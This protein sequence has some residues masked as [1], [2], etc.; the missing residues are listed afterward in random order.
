MMSACTSEVGRLPDRVEPPLVPFED[1][2]VFTDTLRP[3]TAIVVGE[4]SFID[5]DP[6]GNFLVSDPIVNAVYMFDMD[7]VHKQTF[8]HNACLPEKGGRVRSARFGPVGRI[9]ESGAFGP[10]VVFDT[11]GRCLAAEVDDVRAEAACTKGIHS[12][13]YPSISHS[14]GVQASHTLW[15]WRNLVP[16]ILMA[17]SFEG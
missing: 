17:P 10:M 11:H 5:I 13:C 14:R 12:M 8:R 16:R 15:T 6:H 7:G 2:F 3:D 1:L 9:I 4:I